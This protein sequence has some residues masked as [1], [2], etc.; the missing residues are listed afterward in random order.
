MT[1]MISLNPVPQWLR[2]DLAKDIK[3]KIETEKLDAQ[4]SGLN[5][6]TLTHGDLPPEIFIQGT[7]GSLALLILFIKDWLEKRRITVI[8]KKEDGRETITIIGH[9]V[10]NV[11]ESKKIFDPDTHEK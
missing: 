2:Y 11:L 4:L 6:D 5:A 1:Y 3:K 7:A 10:E 9:G 8:Y